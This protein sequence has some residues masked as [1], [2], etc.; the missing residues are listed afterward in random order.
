MRRHLSLM[1]EVLDWPRSSF[2]FFFNI[3]CKNLNFLA[4]PR[5]EGVRHLTAMNMRICSILSLVGMDNRS[6][7]MSTWLRAIWVSDGAWASGQRPGSFLR[8]KMRDE[9]EMIWIVLTL[10]LWIISANF[11]S[12]VKWSEVA[13]LCPTLCDPMDCSLPGSSIRRILE[14]RIVEWV[15]ISYSMGSSQSRDRTEVSHIVGRCFTLW[16]TRETLLTSIERIKLS[17]DPKEKTPLFSVGPQISSITMK[18]V[19]ASLVIILHAC[20][21]YLRDLHICKISWVCL[22]FP[23]WKDFRV[24]TWLNKVS[25]RVKSSEQKKCSTQV[26]VARGAVEQRLGAWIH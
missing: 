22:Q 9:L 7:L 26:G 14:A 16:A 3:L 17:S 15:A 8:Q 4:N 20:W 19:T 2:G 13:Q 24:D 12:E 21:A 10:L 6:D 18:S 11:S 23:E 5:I 25:L 1:R